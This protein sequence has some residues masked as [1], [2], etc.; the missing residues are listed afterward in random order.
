MT[1]FRLFAVMDDFGNLIRVSRI[2]YG[3]FLSERD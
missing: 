1:Y 3:I 2:P